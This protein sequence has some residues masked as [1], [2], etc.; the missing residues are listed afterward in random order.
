MDINNELTP[1]GRILAKLPLDPR[2]GKMIVLGTIFSVPDA[3]AIIAAQS[4]NLSEIF[5]LPLN[6][7]HL[8]PAQRGFAA[9]RHSDHLAILNA[10]QQWLHKSRHGELAEIEFCQQRMLSLP[11]LRMTNEAKVS[12]GSLRDIRID[13]VSLML[14]NFFCFTEPTSASTEFMRVS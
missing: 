7:K 8:A 6:R 12:V 5:N 13:I 14:K 11:A 3:L 9:G 1:L 4:S 10:F 2:L